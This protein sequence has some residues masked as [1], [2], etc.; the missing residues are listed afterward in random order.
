MDAYL[1]LS[2][3][4]AAEAAEILRSPVVIPM[5]V[6]GWK[7][8]TQDVG[9]VTE[10]F[11]RRGLASRLLVLTPGVATAVLASAPA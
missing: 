6:D 2:A 1:T 4:Q 3:D 9:A 10:A 8:L 5:H 11:A 7:H